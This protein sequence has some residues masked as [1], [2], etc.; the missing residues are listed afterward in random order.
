M[1][2]GVG[3]IVIERHRARDA[4]TVGDKSGTVE[5]I[6]IKTTRVRAISGE[7][8]VFGNNDLLSSRVQNFKR[9]QERRVSL[10]LRLVYEVPAETLRRVPALVR[11]AVESASPVRFERCHLKAFGQYSLEFECVYFVTTGDYVTHM[12]AQQAIHLAIFERFAT[13]GIEFAYPTQVQ[14]ARKLAGKS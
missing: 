1:T 5:R 6:G 9:M 10:P 4:I 3:G 13:E 2:L 12:D 14:A 11:E 7:E 8:L